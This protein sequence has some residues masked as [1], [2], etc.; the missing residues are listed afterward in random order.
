MEHI[1][2]LAIT[3]RMTAGGS[4]LDISFG[5]NISEKEVY[6]IFHKLLIVLDLKLENIEFPYKDKEKLH[7]L[8]LLFQKIQQ[9]INILGAL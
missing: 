8:S 1:I 4:Y 6:N 5:Y 9:A 2:Q 3:L 7:D